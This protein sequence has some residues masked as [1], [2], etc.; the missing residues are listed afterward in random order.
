MFLYNTKL[1][2]HFLRLNK[3]I[4]KA[5]GVSLAIHKMLWDHGRPFANGVG[6]TN[7]DVN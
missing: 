6:G 1:F 5:L 2:N 3:E 7:R 4:E